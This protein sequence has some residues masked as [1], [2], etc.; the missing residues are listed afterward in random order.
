MICS[1]ERN[2]HW[3]F[4][5][6]VRKNLLMCNALVVGLS[7]LILFRIENC[8]IYT[9]A[10]KDGSRQHSSLIILL[11]SRKLISYLKNVCGPGT[12]LLHILH[13]LNYGMWF[14]LLEICLIVLSICFIA[15]LLWLGFFFANLNF[16]LYTLIKFYLWLN[17]TF[18]W[19]KHY[20]GFRVFTEK[21]SLLQ[22][23]SSLS[24]S[25]WQGSMKQDECA[26][27][28]SL[29]D[30]YD[31]VNFYAM[32]YMQSVYWIHIGSKIP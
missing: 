3:S 21:L 26:L 29:W 32:S 8:T 12:Q 4:S 16:I 10:Y 27:L 18:S 31:T 30:S 22:T 2:E 20:S 14:L 13:P 1:F 9:F 23:I 15:Y 28:I 17:I 19:R 24:Y 5:I 6:R 11:F 25:V 7:W